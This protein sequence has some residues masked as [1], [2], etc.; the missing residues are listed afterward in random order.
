MHEPSLPYAIPL[1]IVLVLAIVLSYYLFRQRA[2]ADIKILLTTIF[3]AS[4]WATGYLFEL[5]STDI[6]TKVFWAMAQYPFVSLLPVAWFA[7]AIHVAGLHRILSFRYMAPLCTLPV[8]MQPVIWTNDWHLFFWKEIAI[9]NDGPFLLLNLTY[10]PGFW[11][12][13]VYSLLLVGIST[14]Y[15]ISAAAFTRQLHLVQRIILISIPLLP[16]IANLMYTQRWGPVPNLDLTPF[17]FLIAGVALAYGFALYHLERVVL[18]ARTDLLDHLPQAFFVFDVNMRLVDANQSADD[19]CLN[20]LKVHFGKHISDIDDPFL[21]MLSDVNILTLNG[22]EIDHPNNQKTYLASATSI[23]ETNQQQIGSVLTLVD[24]SEQKNVNENLLS[25]RQ[26]AVLAKVEAEAANKAKS[27]FLSQMS[28]E[29][30]TPLN[31]VLGFSQLLL[32]E[33]T[34]SILDSRQKKYMEHIEKGG[35]H[36]IKLIDDILSLATIEAGKINFEKDDIDP[37]PLVDECIN[38]IKPLADKSHITLDTRSFP[39]ISTSITG[40]RVRIKQVVINLLSNAVKY[41]KPGGN[42]YI[43]FENRGDSLRIGIEDTGIGID[44]D[45]KH[46]VF[47]PFARLGAENT[48]I[49]GT[50]IGLTLSRKLIQLM[51]GEMGFDSVRGRGSRFWIDLPA[52]NNLTSIT[53]PQRK[54]YRKTNWRSEFVSKKILYIEDNVLNLTLMRTIVEN[55]EGINLVSAETAELGLDMVKADEPDLILMDINL[56]GMDGFEALALLKKDPTT[57]HIPVVAVTA[58]ATPEDRE[59]GLE[60]GFLKYLTKPFNI[61]EVVDVIRSSLTAPARYSSRAQ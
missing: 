57:T 4:G 14:L 58:A 20:P 19:L 39:D 17:A 37:L 44:D 7:F 48:E 43:D 36:L 59:K 16:V 9:I 53:S 24:I 15:L 22:F 54:N 52:R 27:E 34:G 25:A 50:G 60:L 3:C 40:D 10:G 47:T 28:H 51:S 45:K 13:N 18:L 2:H 42:I 26:A 55:I 38:L 12:V 29:L 61:D 1:M 6:E 56:P 21:Q 23:D 30:R 5:Q 33:G 11:I 8:L 31:A 41:N 35:R 32:D 46:E 49:E